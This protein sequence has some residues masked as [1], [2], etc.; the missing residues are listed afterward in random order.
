MLLS[1]EKGKL[2]EA[3]AMLIEALAVKFLSVPEKIRNRLFSIEDRNQLKQLMK[4]A[5][6]SNTIEQFAAELQ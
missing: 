3:R 4:K 1:R 6:S 5:I 2:T